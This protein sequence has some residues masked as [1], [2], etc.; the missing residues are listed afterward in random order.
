[1]RT[2]AGIFTEAA[3]DLKCGNAEQAL[4]IIMHEVAA[5]QA[6]TDENWGFTAG[7]PRLDELCQRIGRVFCPVVASSLPTRAGA[8]DVYIASEIYG[9]GGHTALIGDYSRHRPDHP[10][11][12]LVTNH[13]NQPKPAPPAA[14]ARTGLPVEAIEV[15][16]ATG[17]VDKVRWLIKRLADLQPERLFLLNHPED[18]TPVAAAQPG[19]ARWLYFVHHADHSP[20]LGVH[21]PCHGHLDV[22]PRAL[23]CCRDF[24]GVARPV[25][26][27]LGCAE[28]IGVWRPRVR[29]AAKGGQRFQPV[30]APPVLA[31]PVHAQAWRGQAGSAA[32]PSA[33]LTTASS[34]AINK[35]SFNGPL[36]YPDVITTLLARTNLR[37]IHF[38]PLPRDVVEGWPRSLA[39]RGIDPAR[40]LHVPRVDSLWQA[41]TD[42]SVDVYLSSFP[43][44][45][46]RSS[47]EVMGSGTPMVFYQANPSAFTT[48]MFLAYPEAESW[49]V[50]E[51]LVAR[52]ETIEDPWLAWQQLCSR[53]H[54]ERFHAAAII[55]PACAGDPI[56]G[57]NPPEFSHEARAIQQSLIASFK[58][59]WLREI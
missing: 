50:P 13:L 36:A 47:V 56:E 11:R 16:S 55:A 53:R 27:P 44:P 37:H 24:L 39:H 2:E 58:E 5:F 31:P 41:M 23:T 9:I 28:P 14:A 6:Q 42:F 4:R 30:V 48:G 12:L 38:G 43:S 20:A 17:L 49:S 15:T 7:F 51:E 46:A 29:S 10:A 54:F 19:L 3:A 45:G 25:Y 8:P 21:L 40:L 57:V 32:L 59:R 1:M 18:P 26:V 35:F 34:G 33:P 22:T 52:L